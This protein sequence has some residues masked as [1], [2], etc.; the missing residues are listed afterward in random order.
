MTTEAMAFERGVSPLLEKI[1]PARLGDVLEF[2][3]DAGIE[4]RIEEL[5]EKS[6]EGDLS[7]EE[8]AEYEGYVRANKFVAVLRR[9]ANRLAHMAP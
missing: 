2:R 4:R 1:L 6:T 9:E 7:V 8:R 3:P 5:A